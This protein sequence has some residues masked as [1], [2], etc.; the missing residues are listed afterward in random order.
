[1]LSNE[2]VHAVRR[3]L[4]SCQRRAWTAEQASIQK[5]RP[6]S[7]G[8]TAVSVAIG[9]SLMST[10]DAQS[11]TGSIYG[12]AGTGGGVVVIENVDTGSKV[13]VTPDANGRYSASTLP[14]GR[15]KV[16]LERDGTTTTREN[17]R[18]V[19]GQGTEVALVGEAL[20]TVMVFG[21]AV[22]QIDMS[23][24]ESK[25][26]FTRELLNNIMTAPNLTQ[27]ALL[28]PGAVQGDSRYGNVPVFTGSSASENAYY[29]DGFPVTQSLTQFG[30]TELPFNSIDQVQ[31]STGGY[32]VEFGRATGGVVSVVTT[33]GTNDWKFGSQYMYRPESAMAT[34]KNIYYGPNGI[35]TGAWGKQGQIYQYR[36]GNVYDRQT[37]ALSASG[38]IL[39]DRLFF[40]VAGEYTDIEGSGTTAGGGSPNG[41]ASSAQQVAQA[42]TR[43]WNEYEQT[44]P[45]WLGRLD[46]NITDQHML[47]VTG[48]QDRI[49]EHD[50]YSGF[51]Y[52]TMSRVGPVSNTY[53]RDR[54]T[55][56]YIG[57]Y[58]GYFTDDLTVSAMYGQSK[59]K[60]EGGPGNYN[61][62][63]PTILVNPGA[64]APGLTY[65]NCQFSGVPSY[66]S[67]RFDETKAW[68]IDVEYRLGSAHTLKAGYDS[69]ETESRVGSSNDGIAYPGALGETFAGGYRWQYFR[70]TRPDGTP[71]PFEPIY[72]PQGV[73]SPGSAGGLGLQ[74]YYVLRQVGLNLS[75]PTAEQKAQYIKDLWQVTDNVMVEIGVRNEQFTN[76]NSAGVAYIDQD[77]QIAPRLGV[78]WDVLGD[79]STKLYASAGRYHLAVPNNVARRGAD[80]ATNTNEAFVYTGV[81][82][83]T[84]APTG[85][86]SLG[87]VYSPNN[88]FGQSRDAKS[89]APTSL[90]SHY[91]DTFAMGVEREFN[92][93][94][95]GRL[96]GGAKFTYSTL[97]SAIDDF[98][99]SR[100]IYEW[101]ATNGS[102]YT[103]DQIDGVADFFGHC[104]LINPGEDNTYRYDIDG[105]G[106]YDRIHLSKELLKFPKLERKYVALDLFVERP[107]DGKWYGRLDYT[108]SQNY[109]NLEG[110]LN[111]DIGQ[112]D[113]S[114]TLAG[115]Y[116]ELATNAGGYLPNDRRHQIKANGY[117]A[118]TPEF[119]VGGAFTASSGRPK[120][121]RGAYP[122]IDP[123][124]PNYGSY[125]FFCNGEPA[126]RGSYGRLPNN[127]RLDLSARYTPT[128]APGLNVG[129]NVYNV[130]NRQSVANVNELYNQG[131]SATTINV[132][133]GRVQSYTLPR[134]VEF[135]VR[136]D[137]GL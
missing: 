72:E 121:C 19:V 13:S 111:S 115:D 31:V 82:P 1:M 83:V 36:E 87:P 99:D 48:L 125:H 70:A 23:T 119:L 30:Y 69:N 67:G 54:N 43:G 5:R 58:T 78:T 107:F 47:S 85:L 27:V 129:L 71:N 17:I 80:G 98:C 81:D 3:V 117:Y 63:C 133:W 12:N 73:G 131:Q 137:F 96:N 32:G 123:D 34:P 68:R 103:D 33:R 91:Q 105:D 75:Q 64:S 116:Y 127:V 95:I 9:M 22:N 65:G 124:S 74:G 41:L 42:R 2:L 134:Y 49:K 94:A 135:Q 14:S 118:L 120:N 50:D 55:R 89:F 24:V 45:R 51:D 92:I 104:V 40:S 130:F 126:P 106:Q 66:L 100:P 109:G 132:N 6:T 113:V 62:D 76:Y 16:T 7:A 122:N 112:I 101:A 102:Q 77:T 8:L 90:E 20:E 10:A 28:A 35:T 108:W 18:V 61:P 60:Y 46:W 97:Q 39:R 88:E 79:S 128:W 26:T 44:L 86:T 136:Y 93:D 52:E 110:Q 21:T 29:I 11:V 114:V 25:L 37:L 53:N 57:N 38:P 15:Y 59:T 4:V 84:G 56:T